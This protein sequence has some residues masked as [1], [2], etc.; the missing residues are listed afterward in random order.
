MTRRGHFARSKSFTVKLNT[1]NLIFGIP[2][3][4][5]IQP[6]QLTTRR[7]F[8]TMNYY[9]LEQSR[10]SYKKCL[11]QDPTMGSANKLV[12]RHLDLLPNTSRSPWGQ[13]GSRQ[14]LQRGEMRSDFHYSRFPVW[15]TRQSFALDVLHNSLQ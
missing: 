11:P 4:T 7:S 13:S 8:I 14:F 15:L 10:Q 1:D 3:S 5:G 12:V 6:W 9:E 2:T